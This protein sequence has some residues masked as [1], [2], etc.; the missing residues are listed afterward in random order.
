MCQTALTNQAARIKKD[1][2][3]REYDSS[4]VSLYE[5]YDQVLQGGAAR[6]FIGQL[7]GNL[8]LDTNT[9]TEL[10]EIEDLESRA[11]AQ[12]V[13]YKDAAQKLYFTIALAQ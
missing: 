7:A 12:E 4:R 9:V 11:E 13:K 6:K 8:R 1:K 10:T 3:E 2:E 5:T